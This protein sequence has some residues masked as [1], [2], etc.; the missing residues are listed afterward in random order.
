VTTRAA[1]IGTTVFAAVLLCCGAV[2]PAHSHASRSGAPP[3]VIPVVVVRLNPAI[4][5][6]IWSSFAVRAQVVI[7]PATGRTVSPPTSSV[8]PPLSKTTRSS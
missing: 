7:D 5:A 6:V 3:A 2:I 1:V 4:G 8:A